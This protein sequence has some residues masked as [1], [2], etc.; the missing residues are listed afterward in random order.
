MIK[1]LIR[2]IKYL[3]NFY[4]LKFNK[5]TSEVIFGKRPFNT[6]FSFNYH[7]I[8]HIVKF[9]KKVISKYFKKEYS[10][11]LD[12]GGGASPYY[13]LFIKHIE[14]FVVLD[15]ENS[16][17]K[18]EI[19]NIIQKIGSAEFIPFSDE[20]F[21]IV[22][23]NQVLE[24]V[25]DDKKAISEISRIL[26]KGGFFIGSVPHISPIHLEPYDYRRYTL[27]GIKKYLEENGFII[28]EIEGNGGVH[29]AMAQTLLM[30]WYLSKNRDGSPQKFHDKLHFILFPINGVINF[31]AIIGDLIITNKLRSPSNYCWIVVKS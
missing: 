20:K 5:K 7:N 3:L 8:S 14:E 1:N 25:Y 18:N 13:D 15:F 21:D 24:H 28:L 9:Q 29:R 17:P 26:R 16:L 31:L 30:D 12:V 27:F 11:L 10:N 2:K 23:C 22:L 6:I 4:F 19:R